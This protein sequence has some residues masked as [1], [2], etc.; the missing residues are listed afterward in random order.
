MRCVAG[1]VAAIAAI[2]G[3]HAF[4]RPPSSANTAAVR[5][6][7]TARFML[8][9]A[10]SGPAN[11]VLPRMAKPRSAPGESQAPQP[12]QWWLNRFSGGCIA[13]ACMPDPAA[14]APVLFWT[15]KPAQ[16]NGCA[17]IAGI[18]GYAQFPGACAI[19]TRASFRLG[20]DA[21]SAREDPGQA[22]G[23]VFLSAEMSA[24]KWL[25]MVYA[26]YLGTL[27]LFQ[28]RFVFDP[29]HASGPKIAPTDTHDVVPVRLGLGR[30]KSIKGWF[31]RPRNGG[32]RF[33]AIIY[34]GGRSEDVAWLK[35]AVRWFPDHALLA[36]NYRGYGESEGR[37]SEHGLFEDGLAQ[38][39]WLAARAE[40]DPEAIVLAGRSLGT[41]VAVYVA[42]HRPAERVV[43]ITPYDSLLALARRRFRF[44]P[45]SLLLRHKFRSVDYAKSNR[46]PCLALIAERDDVVPEE[47]THRLM[48]S[49]AGAGKL[50]RIP[51]TTH[52]NMPYKADTLATVAAWLGYS[53]PPSARLAR[54]SVGTRP[55]TPQ[56]ASGV[57]A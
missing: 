38:F 29:K 55:A 15:E 37:P 34:F 52:M 22:G 21:N 26:T 6:G 23:S 31:L 35:G 10:S 28:R 19:A 30:N 33:P 43:L 49:W 51:N 44:I 12:V 48:A 27:T 32:E 20:T 56:T 17:D 2:V 8:A 24:S 5:G 14:I 50:V 42:A 46:Q 3:G 53:K 36:L 16:V 40:I 57:C 4:A 11:A 45:L 7:E 9:L 1:A 13:P 25:L 18:A 54:T 47:H 41:G 39:D